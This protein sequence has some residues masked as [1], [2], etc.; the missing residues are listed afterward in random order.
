M[1]SKCPSCEALSII[2]LKSEWS[3]FDS[4]DYNVV[5]FIDNDDSDDD[6]DD[7]TICAEP[8]SLSDYSDLFYQSFRLTITFTLVIAVFLL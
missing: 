7:A 3:D 6:D 2:S 1:S 8:L 5:N 4:L